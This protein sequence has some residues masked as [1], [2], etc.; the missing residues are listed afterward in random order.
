LDL[1]PEH[2][3]LRLR[4]S[5]TVSLM[6]QQPPDRILVDAVLSGDDEAFRVLVDRES[7]NV[8]GM[9]RRVL[10]DPHEAEDV[11]Q[12]AFLQAYR[13]LPTFRG[14]GPFGAWVW[15]IASRLAFA[16]LKRRPPELQADPSRAEGW[17]EP[18]VEDLDPAGMVLVGEQRADVKE[19]VSKLPPAQRQVVT[20][21]FYSDLSLEEI[22]NQTG[23]PVGTV[24]SRLH[25]ALASLRGSIES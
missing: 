22:S 7:A 15:R 10:G 14:D 18:T 9:C 5:C 8:I 19:A 13:A 12:D 16:R 21:R 1:L 4:S 2:L 23:A 11:A 24:K 25:R 17:L 3:R 6:A 20:L